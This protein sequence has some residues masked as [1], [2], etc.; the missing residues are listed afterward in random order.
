MTFLISCKLFKSRFKVSDGKSKDV[1][2]V[3][4]HHATAKLVLDEIN[5]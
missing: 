1:V 2:K 5:V 3:F 4:I